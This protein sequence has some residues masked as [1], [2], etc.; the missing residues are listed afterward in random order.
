M[1][2]DANTSI[3]AETVSAKSGSKRLLLGM[4]SKTRAAYPQIYPQIASSVAP[5]SAIYPGLLRAQK[6]LALFVPYSII[7]FLPRPQYMPSLLII[8]KYDAEDAKAFK[9]QVLFNETFRRAE[10]IVLR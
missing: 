4:F 5:Q 10:C 8:Q 7:K 1:H 9:A 2:S 6:Y 3:E